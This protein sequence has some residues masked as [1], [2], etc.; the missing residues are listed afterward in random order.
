[1]DFDRFLKQLGYKS[2]GWGYHT[3]EQYEKNISHLDKI[4]N[5][6]ETSGLYPEHLSKVK[7]EFYSV[8]RNYGYHINS[9]LKYKNMVDEAEESL[10]SDDLTDEPERLAAYNFLCDD[11]TFGYKNWEEMYDEY[12]RLQKYTERVDEL[13]NRVET[14]NDPK[15]K[16]RVED[17]I[18]KY[19]EEV[20]Y[21]NENS[22]ANLS[23]VSNTYYGGLSEFTVLAGNYHVSKD[24]VYSGTDDEWDKALRSYIEDMDFSGHD[25][26]Y[27]SNFIDWYSVWNSVKDDE[28]E[29]SE[30]MIQNNPTNYFDS[31]ELVLSDEQLSEIQELENERKDL[32]PN[33][34]SE[35][36]EEI[37]TEIESI[38]DNPVGFDHSMLDEKIEELLADIKSKIEDD[39]YSYLR[40]EDLSITY[41]IDWDEV[42]DDYYRDSDYGLLTYDDSY[43]YYRIEGRTYYVGWYDKG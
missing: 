4:I 29:K 9:E 40:K 33:E 21:F 22:I 10:E 20:E 3:S 37:E 39:A 15:K 35:R 30:G 16:K 17:F 36:I 23:K 8:N 11:G 25:D 42:Y 5:W 2:L 32:D 12:K 27:F 34:D 18:T 14:I 6:L 19:D 43:N 13:R 24:V 26:D 38:R 7:E 1:M 41:Y 28:R 31:D